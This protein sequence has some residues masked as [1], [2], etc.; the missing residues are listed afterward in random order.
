MIRRP[1]CT[2]WTECS[3]LPKRMAFQA[4]RSGFL[5]VMASSLLGAFISLCFRSYY[6]LL[7]P[8]SAGYLAFDHSRTSFYPLFLQVLRRGV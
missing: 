2:V 3:E 7:Q 1:V 6:P 5:F 8:D 4:L